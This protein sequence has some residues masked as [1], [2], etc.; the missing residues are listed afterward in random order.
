MGKCDERVWEDRLIENI[1]SLETV[2]FTLIT[3]YA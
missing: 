1:S 2:L 3:A